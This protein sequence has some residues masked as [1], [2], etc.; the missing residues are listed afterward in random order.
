MRLIDGR[1][2]RGNSR[3]RTRTKTVEVR[4]VRPQEPTRANELV[5]K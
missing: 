2:K 5:S 3:E 4:I 1:A